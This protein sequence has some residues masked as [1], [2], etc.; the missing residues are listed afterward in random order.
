MAKEGVQGSGS[1]QIIIAA[2]N[3]E[4]GIGL[5]ISEL[6]KTLKNPRILVVDGKSTDRTV[7]I[8]KNMGANVV[9]Q[10]GLG[11]GDALAK[12]IAHSDLTVDYVVIT[13]ADYTYPAEHVPEMIRVLEKNPEVGMVCGNRFSGYVDLKGLSYFFY[14]GNRV[15]AFTQNV[16]NGVWLADPLTGLRVV[17]AEILRN[18]KVKSKG[19]DVEVELNI[20]V[21]REGFGIAE[22][23]IKY[24]ERLGE[25]KLGVK[26]GAEILR[27]I[28]LESTY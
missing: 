23:P 26:H 25:K 2:L 19:F 5:T 7:E 22:V 24:R 10:D 12:A 6:N 14:L 17:R 8:A 27:R 11:K 3:E 28:L 16:L 4:Q 9:C 15:I 21:K 18:W 1:I 13:D 20:K